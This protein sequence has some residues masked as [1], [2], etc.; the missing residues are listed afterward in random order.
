MNLESLMSQSCFHCS[1]LEHQAR[2]AIEKNK[3]AEQREQG[4]GEHQLQS[5]EGHWSSAFSGESQKEVRASETS[6]NALLMGLR[7]YDPLKYFL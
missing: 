6:F 5:E 3:Y 1:D 7:F 4:H 2:L